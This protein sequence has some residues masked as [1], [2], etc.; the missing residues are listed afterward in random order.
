MADLDPIEIPFE[1]NSQELIGELSR[2]ISSAKA[3]DTTISSAHTAFDDFISSLEDMSSKVSQSESITDKQVNTLA[4][5]NEQLEWLKVAQSETNDPTQLAIYQKQLEDIA[6]AMQKIV[7]TTGKPAM[8]LSAD[9]ITDANSHLQEAQKLIDQISDTH[10][11]PFAS[12]EELEVLSENINATTDSFE[13]LQVVL[14]FVQVKME[15]M[16]QSSE[17]F[18]ELQKEIAAAKSLLSAFPPA[19]DVTGQ[20]INSMTDALKL[21]QDQLMDATDPAEVVQLNENIEALENRI[22]QIKNAGKEGFDDFGNKLEE[23]SED[24]KRLRSELESLIDQMAKLRLENKENSEEYKALQAEAI[25]A[26]DAL[27]V[28]G[29]EVNKDATKA[30]KFERLIQASSGIVAGFSAAQGAMALFG[31]EN[32]N[33]EKTIEKVTGAMAVLQALQ[34]IQVQLKNADTTAT[35]QQTIAQSLY[36]TV[37]GTSS[38]ALKVFRIAL[39]ATGIGLAVLL[40][41]ALVANWDKVSESI[42]KNIP[43]LNNFGDKLDSLKSYAMGFLSAYLSLFNTIFKTLQKVIDLD[44]KGAIKELENTGK[45]AV[46]AFNNGKKEQDNKNY[47]NKVNDVLDVAVKNIDK[48]IAI[49]EAGGKKTDALHRRKFEI[50][51]KRYKDDKEK[52]AENAQ[53]KAVFEAGVQKRINDENK[54]ALDKRHQQQEAA[55]K[56]AQAL[57]EKSARERAEI[58]DKIN[59]EI[60][61]LNTK[62]T[63]GNEIAK[64]KAKWDALKAEAQKKGL[65]K[66]LI[67]KIDLSSIREQDIA[68]Y[69]AE[70]AEKMKELAHQKELY[71]AYEG[72]KTSLA[73]TEFA[74]RNNINL[75][76]F[77]TFSDI[78]DAEIAKLKEKATLTDLE[79]KRLEG[80]Q[81]MK[82]GVDNDDS[83]KDFA[84]YETAIQD[85]ITY[86]EQLEAIKKEFADKELQLQKITDTQ[87]RNAK[88]AENERMKQDAIDS[89]N[90]EAYEKSEIYRQLSANIYEL[91]KKDLAQRIEAL[92][93][94]LQ[95][96]QNLTPEQREEIETDL[97]GLENLQAQSDIMVQHNALVERKKQLI[98]SINSDA[99][100]SIEQAIAEQVELAKINDELKKTVALKAKAL[101]EG[102][103]QLASGFHEMASAI[104]DSNEGLAST[105]DTVGDILDVA[106]DAAGAFASFAS[107][108]I[109]GG[110]TGIMKTISGIFSIGKKARESEKK[111]QEEI[112][113]RQQE[114]IQAM[115]DYNATLRQ[116]M[117]DET[118]INDLYQS[119]VTNIRE[120]MAARKVALQKNLQDQQMLFNKLLGMTTVVGQHTEK[121]GGF[122]GIGKKTRVVDETNSLSNLLGVNAGTEITDELFEKLER[123]NAQ[124]PLSGDAKNAYEQ[125]KKLRD[126]YGSFAEANRQLEIQLKNAIT[127]TTAQS[128]ADSIREGLKSG[129]KSFADF[130]NDIEGFLREAI[131]AG[132][133]AK[134]I[135][136]QIQ[137]LQDALADMMGDG[138]LSAEERAQFQ[139]MYMAIANSSQEY[140]DIINQAGVGIGNSASNAN[141]L[142]GAIKGMSQESADI[143]SGQLGGLRLT[144]LETNSILKNG[145]AQQLQH[146]SQMVRLQIDI[147]KNTKRTAENTDK[148]YDVD[149]NIVRVAE[150][151]DKHYKSLQAAG[152]IK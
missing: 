68:K 17:S 130:A 142:A 123:L 62:E 27:A 74:K 99:P 54:R 63:E 57:A 88:L 84:K 111:A 39:A 12:P 118:K 117:I 92:K 77:G 53:A 10:I 151:Q 119:R 34:E 91:T 90:S 30:T 24:S 85:T 134:I 86:N 143:M 128:L 26:R 93:A 1:I 81:N 145:F 20:S 70:T 18:S 115:L 150:G 48:E 136:P 100:K 121:Y 75:E 97:K 103:K 113:K 43:W 112:K 125:L 105:L 9:E 110:I 95:Q 6:A 149:K 46:D 45:N 96:A 16:D 133:S 50:L 4:R 14:D 138:I 73:K 56:K 8:V 120:E 132:I 64:I 31:Q 42:K 126:E 124:H 140:M 116:R 83:K 122:L 35:G 38:G 109:I 129:K 139:E 52:Y 28:V 79:E 49:A 37:V 41:G 94:F 127:G 72:L 2:I 55:A 32:E 106:G 60:D 101:S 59:A 135:E 58:R 144:Q 76:E 78:L 102:A 51:E 89:L 71:A 61:K 7:E 66:G 98:D 13:Q 23:Q 137:A 19:V 36:T 33:A 107:G 104:G 3:V 87:L 147:E 21:F 131:M 22:K 44:L 146:T 47:D 67:M 69:K 152:I 5:L 65:D 15:E 29:Q 148:L 82:T 80:L 108:D 141:S 11:Q 40:I 25:R 114:Q